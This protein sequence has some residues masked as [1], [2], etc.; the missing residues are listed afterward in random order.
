MADEMDGRLLDPDSQQYQ[1]PLQNLRRLA[2]SGTQFKQAYTASPLCTPSRSSM[3]TGRH[4]SDIRVYSNG[5]GLA[6]V[7]GDKDRIDENCIRELGDD[8]QNFGAFQNSDGTFIDD[9]AEAGYGINLYGKLHV[10]AG[11]GRFAKIPDD[12]SGNA[13]FGGFEGPDQTDFVKEWT[14]ATGVN[15]HFDWSIAGQKLPMTG[16]LVDDEYPAHPKDY[17]TATRCAR[18]LKNGLFTNSTPQLLYCSLQVP[19][20]DLRTNLTYYNRID[21]G[22]WEMPVWPSKDKVHPADQY[23]AE[24]KASWGADLAPREDVVLARRVYFSMCEE[25][26]DL[27]GQILDGLD[28]GGG[29]ENSFIIFVSDHGHHAYENFAYGKDSLREAA[30]RVPIIISGPGVPAQGGIFTLASLHD[31]YPTII[32]M[33]GVGVTDRRSTW[34]KT[35]TG[36]SLLPLAQGENRQKKYVIAEYHSRGS[37]TG[38]FMIATGSWKMTVFG[39]PQLGGQQWKPQLYNLDR[40]PHELEDLAETEK[41]KVKQLE[42]YLRS[43]IDIEAVDK[44]KK[45]YDKLMFKKYF[46]DKHGGAANCSEA[47]SEV[48]YGFT[49]EDATKVETWLGQPCK[50][51]PYMRQKRDHKVLENLISLT[52]GEED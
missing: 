44:E 6:Y 29:R 32:D 16:K 34:P 23:T 49:E 20:P 42:G 50:G 15:N 25:A 18:R 3:M 26:D 19:H 12:V 48:Y 39:A 35:W 14:R 43:E 5:F 21:L 24:L 47:M 11:L 22:K 31:I 30:A 41:A 7:D 46:Y 52:L 10:G 8:C 51:H 1:P 28:E 40:D 17:L 36:E 4:S 9:L 13:P 2:Q 27:V 45:Y 38:E 37:G 33:A